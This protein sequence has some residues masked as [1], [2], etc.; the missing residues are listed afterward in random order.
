MNADTFRDI[1]S[2]SKLDHV[3]LIVR[4][5]KLIAALISVK[6]T[7]S[8]A[9][10]RASRMSG[11]QVLLISKIFWGKLLPDFALIPNYN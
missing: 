1:I 5:K 8:A 7:I 3:T 10:L 9:C 2:L 4:K 11:Y 6:M